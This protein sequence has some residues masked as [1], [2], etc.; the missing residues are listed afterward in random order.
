MPSL[1][2]Y[3][4]KI[5]LIIH[6]Y[7]S[8]KPT[9]HSFVFVHIQHFDKQ[10][11]IQQLKITKSNEFQ[12]QNR[13]TKKKKLLFKFN[14][15]ASVKFNARMVSSSVFTKRLYFCCC[16]CWSW[17]LWEMVCFT[18]CVIVLL[19]QSHTMTSFSIQ[20]LSIYQKSE[21]VTCKCPV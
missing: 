8:T 2:W 18:R 10:T 6:M 1:Q 7:P 16:C 11:Q 17:S 20:F 14:C 21:R 15:S 4:P 19:V 5:N 12:F 9:C 3:R 13:F